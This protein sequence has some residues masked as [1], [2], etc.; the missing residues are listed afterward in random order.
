MFMQ[1]EDD[2]IAALSC[3]HVLG[4]RGAGYTVTQ[5]AVTD[6]R[7]S[8]P[9]GETL[10][11]RQWEIVTYGERTCMA[12]YQFFSIAEER[13]VDKKRLCLSR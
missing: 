3:A 9:M 10:A 8:Y 12:D 2:S 11:N 7:K 6:F 4:D 5:P 1:R 13:T